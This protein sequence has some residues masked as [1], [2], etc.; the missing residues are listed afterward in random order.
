ML[1]RTAS[2]TFHILMPALRGE[3]GTCQGRAADADQDKDQAGRTILPTG[4]YAWEERS[5]IQVGAFEHAEA[6]Q[7]TGTRNV[8]RMER[9]GLGAARVSSLKENSRQARGLDAVG[10]GDGIRLKAK[11]YKD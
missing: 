2:V 10:P 7:E 3:S 4:G 5:F 1:E 6:G 8:A 9:V 11:R